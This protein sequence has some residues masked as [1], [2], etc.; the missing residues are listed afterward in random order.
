MSMGKWR[1]QMK[2]LL[3]ALA[4]ICV[5][6]SA[7][8]G[9]TRISYPAEMLGTWCQV[10]IETGWAFYERGKCTGAVNSIVLSPNGDYVRIAPLW[11]RVT[12]DERCKAIPKSYFK[13]WTDYVCTIGNGNGAASWTE[14]RNQKWVTYEGQAGRLGLG[15]ASWT[16]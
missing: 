3:T 7:F 6:S 12:V 15:G 10:E 8:A 4:L 11:E 1:N 14:K 13:G 2:T 9:S 5:A 16:E